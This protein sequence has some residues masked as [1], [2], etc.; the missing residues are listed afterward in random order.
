MDRDRYHKELV[1][2]DRQL[3]AAAFLAQHRSER[4]EV[5][6]VASVGTVANRAVI[7]SATVGV[8]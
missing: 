7:C 4:P 2:A 5:R 1:R 6:R 8:A 3:R